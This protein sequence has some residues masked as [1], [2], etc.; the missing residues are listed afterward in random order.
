MP[1][2]K[3]N[4]ILGFFCFFLWF[5][6]LLQHPIEKLIKI[7]S[8]FIYC[9]VLLT[10]TVSRMFQFSLF[11]VKNS[12]HFGFRVIF[13]SILG[14]SLNLGEIHGGIAKTANFKVIYCF[15]PSHAKYKFTI[16]FKTLTIHFYLSFFVKLNL[17]LGM[18]LF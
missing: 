3:Q 14:K 8:L 10:K 12:C 7:Y 6:R 13:L 15:N 16:S 9:D 5:P 2:F 11:S 18:Y 1:Y 4:I 17:V